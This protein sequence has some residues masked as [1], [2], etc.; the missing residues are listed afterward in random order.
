MKKAN[1]KTQA[2]QE[3]FCLAIS[4]TNG[5]V[6]HIPFVKA[7]DRDDAF[8]QMVNTNSIWWSFPECGITFRAENIC[9]I[10]KIQK[11][12]EEIKSEQDFK[13]KNHRI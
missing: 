2:S 10:I 6:E 5:N 13:R 8:D 7:K 9:T 1:T 3:L 4:L 12:V 11:T